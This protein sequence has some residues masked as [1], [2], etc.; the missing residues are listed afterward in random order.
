VLHQRV[1]VRCGYPP[2]AY[3]W[4]MPDD[5]TP[6]GEQPDFEEVV[7]ALLQVDPTGIIGK[8]GK[9]ARKAKGEGSERAT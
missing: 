8:E 7:A 2:R 9:D 4:V 5:S 1:Y 6:D 3:R